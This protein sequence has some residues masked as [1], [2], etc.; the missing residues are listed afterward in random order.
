M[1]QRTK[2]I[3]TAFLL[4]N[5][6]LPAQEALSPEKA[7]ELALKNNYAI[8]IARNDQLSVEAGTTRGNAGML[9]RLDI[10]G[11]GN[12]QSTNINQRFSNGLSVATTG[13]SSNATNASAVLGWTLFDG[14]KM[15]LSWDRLKEQQVLSGVQL[16][17]AIEQNMAEVLDAYFQIIRLQQEVKSRTYGLDIAEEQLLITRR[18]VE[19]G[20]SSR[21]ETLQV[22]VDRNTAKSQLLLQQMNLA[23]AQ[24][25]LYRLI[26]ISLDSRFVFPEVVANGFTPKLE[27]IRKRALEQNTGLLLA[28]GNQTLNQFRLRE[29]KAERSP[30][31]KLNA[32]YNFTRSSSTAGFALFN[33]STGPI[34]GLTLSW[35]VFN[36]GMLN[37]RMKQSQFVL[38][39]DA[40]RIKQEEALV[41][42]SVMIAIRQWQ[43]ASELLSLEEE[44]FLSAKEN[45]SLALER[46][47]LGNAGILVLKEAQRSFEEAINR[48]TSAAYTAKQAEI[49]L[50]RL[51]G[52]LVKE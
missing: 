37:T 39:S 38:E 51:A 17:D 36:G 22:I 29:I 25:S 44:N 27:E 35:N 24:T 13:V 19:I 41:D 5:Q 26:G 12:V 32:G 33:Q 42:A 6:L 52:A 28:K 46:I 3:L 4:A 47:R 48:Q 45:L 10:N 23:N 2:L 30:V 20:S 21:Q 49:A 50:L 8:L 40:L 15:F 14:G 7:V 9:P 16:R 43:Q 11:G 1:M 34:G 18:K 31:L